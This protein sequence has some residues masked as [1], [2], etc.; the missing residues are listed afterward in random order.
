MPEQLNESA[1]QQIRQIVRQLAGKKGLSPEVAEEIGG[2]LEDKLLGYLSGEVRITQDDALLLA[3]AHFGDAAG[4]AQQLTDC[5]AATGPEA[6]RRRK[7]QS[8]STK[9][10]LCTLVFLPITLVL[11]GQPPE[12]L[13]SFL[14]AALI[15]LAGLG[16]LETGV[17]LAART[18]LQ[19][20]WQRAV[21]A[22]FVVPSLVVLCL[23]GLSGLSA[24][25]GSFNSAARGGYGII[26]A[27][28]FGCWIGHCLLFL[29]LTA[30][31]PR[32]SPT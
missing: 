3:R 1:I 30:P 26:A 13:E 7:I 9:T 14:Q 29:L 12:K 11:F 16:V 21:A 15:V 4:V 6:G 5:T 2:H 24:F 10:A 18:D 31:L 25:A 32:R 8:L 20:L 28:V 19:S 22:A 27:T 17:L 23:A